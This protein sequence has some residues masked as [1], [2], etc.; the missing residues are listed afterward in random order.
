MEFIDVAKVV[1]VEQTDRADQYIGLGWKLLRLY[2]T[3]YDTEGPR[4]YHQTPHF[5][6][7]WPTEGGE[8]KF[9]EI[10]WELES[11]KIY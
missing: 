7:G 9:P 11:V 10:P 6:L 4:V 1:E 5:I 3:A 2:T 8:P